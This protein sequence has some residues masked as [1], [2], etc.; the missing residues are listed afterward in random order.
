MITNMKSFCTKSSSSR[1]RLVSPLL[2]LASACLL[3][4]APQAGAVVINGNDWEYGYYGSQIPLVSNVNTWTNYVGSAT[5][6]PY[7]SGSNLVIDTNQQLDQVAYFNAVQWNPSTVTGIASLE[8]RMKL[9]AVMP[10]GTVNA[11]I[12]L[13]LFTPVGG[14]SFYYSAGGLA[15]ASDPGTPVVTD[16]DPFQMNTY[17]MIINVN[18]N[19]YSLSINGDQKLASAP[20]DPTLAF[21]ILRIG[22]PATGTGGIVQYEYIAWNNSSAPI[23]EPS[24]ALLLPV[25][26]G[27]VAFARF[28]RK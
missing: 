12:G 15:F 16:F 18:A 7:Y 26:F 19:T 27:L 1:T 13:S 20:L 4:A 24:A 25:A 28:R 11:T 9:D 14:T 22:D 17:T 8:M 21:N 2:G 5:N 6:S 23:P 3:A 10:G